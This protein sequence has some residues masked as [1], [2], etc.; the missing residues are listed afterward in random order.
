M[1]GGGGGGG[2]HSLFS[3]YF[4][5]HSLPLFMVGR[6]SS[7]TSIQFIAHNNAIQGSSQSGKEGGAPL[8]VAKSL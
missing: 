5:G 3:F 6:H 4:R 8:F 1:G 2:G 7:P